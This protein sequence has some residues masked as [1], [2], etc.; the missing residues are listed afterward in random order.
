MLGNHTDIAAGIGIFLFVFRRLC[1]TIINKLQSSFT[2]CISHTTIL[3]QTIHT[4]TRRM[5]TV[6]VIG[7][8]DQRHNKSC[9]CHYCTSLLDGLRLAIHEA[10]KQSAIK[11]DSFLSAVP[12]TVAGMGLSFLFGKVLKQLSQAQA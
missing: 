5:L 8:Y 2:E 6:I 11:A 12:L 10:G 7:L 3:E 1:H 9:H 4:L